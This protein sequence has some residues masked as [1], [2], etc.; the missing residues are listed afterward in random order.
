MDPNNVSQKSFWPTYHWL[1]DNIYG[2]EGFRV[3]VKANFV[4]AIRDSG[5]ISV[6]TIEYFLS[7][8]G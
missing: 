4:K 8:F 2:D 1:S 5:T 6:E 7:G 3:H